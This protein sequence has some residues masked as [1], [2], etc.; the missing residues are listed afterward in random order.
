MK[1]F[2]KEY[3]WLLLV[4]IIGFIIGYKRN[5]WFGKKKSTTVTTTTRSASCSDY[6]DICPPGYTANVVNGKCKCTAS[7]R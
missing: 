6:G 3:W 1:Q 7:V 2:I 4:F 5:D